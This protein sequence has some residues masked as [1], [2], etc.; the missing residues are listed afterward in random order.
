MADF[1]SDEV[2]VETLGES[3][4]EDVGDILVITGLSGMTPDRPF[5][6]SDSLSDPL[7][8]A[9]KRLSDRSSEVTL[10]GTAMVYSMRAVEDRRRRR[11]S[12][13]LICSN[14][15][16]VINLSSNDKAKAKARL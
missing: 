2:Y 9:A 16:I 15:V 4:G 8:T 1:L 12:R 13:L 10:P 6:V 7:L 11:K 5:L 14:F 3:V